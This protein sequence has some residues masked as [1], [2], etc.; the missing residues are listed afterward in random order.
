MSATS[1]PPQEQLQANTSAQLDPTTQST[2]TAQEASHRLAEAIDDFLGDLDKKFSNIS[3]EILTRLDDMAERCD[4]LEQEILL[5]DSG[6]V[7]GLGIGESAKD[8]DTTG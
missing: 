1:P 8:G 6:A 4:R 7:K 3:N 5:R 2:S